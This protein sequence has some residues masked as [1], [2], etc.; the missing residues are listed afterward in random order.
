MLQVNLAIVAGVVVRGPAASQP[1]HSGR[2]SR[3][4]RAHVA[5]GAAP[6]PVRAV[7]AAARALVSVDV[8]I[9]AC[10]EGRDRDIPSGRMIYNPD[11]R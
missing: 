8:N 1:R 4:A 5:A 3:H 11:V 6:S 2:G 9:F 10:R 7:R